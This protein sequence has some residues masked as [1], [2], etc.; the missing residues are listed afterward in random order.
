M[1]Q[2]W[3]IVLIRP[4]LQTAMLC[5]AIY[6]DQFFL[7]LI[8]KEEHFDLILVEGLLNGCALPLIGA[9]KVPFN[10]FNLQF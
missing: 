2:A 3:L 5:Q 10:L 7:Q 8:N 4:F 9:H 1:Y 6:E